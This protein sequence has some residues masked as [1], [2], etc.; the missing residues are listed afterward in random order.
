MSVANLAGLIV[1]RITPR[2][3]IEYL[4]ICKK[5]FNR[6]SHW[7]PPK[8]RIIGSEDEL[9]CAT[10]E[11]LDQTGLGGDQLLIDESFRADLKYVDGVKPKQ[12]VY[13]LARNVTSSR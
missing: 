11:T 5:N 1:Y 9:N 10:R 7:Y 12:V 8:G 6:Y 2:G 4:L 13:V 3:P